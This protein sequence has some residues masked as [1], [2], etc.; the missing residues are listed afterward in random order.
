MNDVSGNEWTYIYSKQ[1]SR[2]SVRV[3]NIT[4]NI[5]MLVEATTMSLW[6]TQDADGLGYG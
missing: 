2:I 6:S 5:A 4:L 1:T 3:W